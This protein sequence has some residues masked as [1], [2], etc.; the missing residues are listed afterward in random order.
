MTVYWSS[1]IDWVGTLFAVFKF[2]VDSDRSSFLLF[3]SPFDFA[4][5][6]VLLVSRPLESES[7]LSS[8]Y[9]VFCSHSL[10]PSTTPSTTS[11]PQPLPSLSSLSSSDEKVLILNLQ[12]ESIF[13]PVNFTEREKS[14]RV[15]FLLSKIDWKERKKAFGWNRKESSPRPIARNFT[16]PG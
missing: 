4:D 11:S 10:E 12:V 6:I 13:N 16:L 2:L 7:P 9:T 14:Q 1:F 8:R 5:S 15:T 3:E